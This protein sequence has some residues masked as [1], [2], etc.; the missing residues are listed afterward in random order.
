MHPAFQLD[1]L[2]NVN[3]TL[4]SNEHDLSK[5]SN[6]SNM[7]YLIYNTF[8]RWCYF[9][10]QGCLPTCHIFDC[11][12]LPSVHYNTRDVCTKILNSIS[13]YLLQTPALACSSEFSRTS[14]CHMY[15]YEWLCSPSATALTI[16]AKQ[17]GSNQG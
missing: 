15:N 9:L 1:L 13:V 2:F 4:I 14:Q 17:S 11:Y 3:Q 8:S 7:S 10:C 5:L 12:I 6:E 16:Q